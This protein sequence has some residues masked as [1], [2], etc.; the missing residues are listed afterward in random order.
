MRP[1]TRR[2]PCG[3]PVPEAIHR[4]GIRAHHITVA[5]PQSPN[6]FCCAVTRVIQDVFAAI[7]LLRPADCAAGRGLP[8][9]L[10]AEKT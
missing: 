2:W 6:A 3:R 10:T 4:V 5:D 7:V 9:R 1:R 8:E